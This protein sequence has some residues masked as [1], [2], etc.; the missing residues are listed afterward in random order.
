VC[1]CRRRSAGG[2]RSDTNNLGQGGF[3]GRVGRCAL[4]VCDTGSTDG[5]L[6][7]IQNEPKR[8]SRIIA[9]PWKPIVFHQGA[10]AVIFEKWHCAE[11]GDWFAKVDEDEILRCAAA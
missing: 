4:Y 6:D 5:T 1:G 9:T 10:R 2:F 11:A 8:D 3:W 7:V